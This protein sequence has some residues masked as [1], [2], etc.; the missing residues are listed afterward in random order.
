[1]MPEAGNGQE[2]SPSA[3]TNRSQSSARR[4][5]SN[6]ADSSDAIEA[7]TE[8][9]R[10]IAISASEMGTMEAV[11]VREGDTVKAGDLVA[12]LDDQVLQAALEVAR[13]GMLAKG[14]LKSAAAEVSMRQT[15]HDKLMELRERNHASQ[16]EVDRVETE[17]QIAQ[18]RVIAAQEDIR[19]K[20]LEFKRI[21]AQME[22][23]RIRT[24][25][26]GVVTDVLKEVGEFV[27]PT[28]SVVVRVVQLDPLLIVFSVPLELRHKIKRDQHV[29]LRLEDGTRSA[30][31]RTAEGIVEYV[32]PTADQSN[33]SIRV[34]VRL[35][36][37]NGQFQ[38]GERTVLSLDPL[39]SPGN[40]EASPLAK[41]DR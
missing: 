34:K 22:Q 4:S 19:I 24:P 15:E 16:R 38:A 2:R 39:N 25:I 32:S 6:E 26:D 40:S 29:G 23:K 17:L 13:A 7:F 21:E 33:T 31:T 1:M 18:A 10:D 35:P 3:N 30:G 11:H 12:G 41:N 5:E 20:E 37:P 8:P 28:D 27:S 36:N 14:Q 9:Y